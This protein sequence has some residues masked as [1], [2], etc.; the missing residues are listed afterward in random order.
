MLHGLACEWEAAQWVLQPEHSRLM[1]K[2]LFSLRDLMKTWGYWS[3]SKEEICLSRRLVLDHPWDAVREVL[4]H[5]M[6]HQFAHQVLGARKESPHGPSFLK[7]CVLLRANPKASGIFPLLQE[8]VFR[9]SINDADKTLI[10]IRKLLALAKSQNQHEAEAAMIK[11]HELIAKYNVDLL[12]VEK[13]RNFAS[14]FLGKP[15][16]RHFRDA[17]HLARLIQDFYYVQ[18]IWVPVYVA[19]KG[20]MGRVLEI[21]GT[22]QNLAMASYVYDFVKRFIRSQWCVYNKEK[23]LNQHRRTDYAVGIIEGFKEK[24]T[25]Q[26]QNRKTPT[27][28]FELIAVNDPLLKKYM[29]HKYPYTKSFQRN[30][31][32]QDETVLKDGMQAGKKL[33]I[34]KGIV[35]K[36]V[37]KKALI[38]A[39]KRFHSPSNFQD[40]S[41]T[42]E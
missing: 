31:S 33:V 28:K 11:A 25:T 30:V 13:K 4:M 6:A 19:E 10:R 14:M 3:E 23:V 41:S 32:H 37:G 39:P 21:S 26:K 7:A 36:R 42:D 8:R 22:R 38:E 16:L 34:H 1:K 40:S 12:A 24:L 20:K 18:G 17:Y 15:A 9:G 35:E 2:P 29:K 5:E 27:H